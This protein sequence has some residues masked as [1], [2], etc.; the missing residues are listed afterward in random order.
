[1]KECKM[2][3]KSL[4]EIVKDGIIW[5]ELRELCFHNPK[6]TISSHPFIFADRG[7]EYQMMAIC[8][9]RYSEKVFEAN[10]ISRVYEEDIKYLCS[11]YDDAVCLGDTESMIKS[12]LPETI[13]IVKSRTE[14]CRQLI[15]DGYEMEADYIWRKKGKKSFTPSMFDYCGKEPKNYNFEPQWL[16]EKL[17]Y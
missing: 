17:Q 13:K 6:R 4:K 1:M 12:Y 15:D 2:R 10:A 3:G 14:I 8:G 9:N 5:R 7:L 16:E 11:Y